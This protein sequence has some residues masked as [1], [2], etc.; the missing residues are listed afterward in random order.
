MKNYI[1]LD[2]ITERKLIGEIDKWHYKISE[3]D[4]I[5]VR[6][7]IFSCVKNHIISIPQIY[8]I[9]CL[10]SEN[11]TRTIL[12]ARTLKG[13]Y[14]VKK[15]EK[16]QLF[17]RMISYN[18]KKLWLIEFDRKNEMCKLLFALL[19]LNFNQ[20]SKGKGLTRFNR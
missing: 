4:F 2:P 14:K 16:I 18:E 8:H 7:I 20:Q 6:N 9:I 10:L 5:N 1:R 12:K 3:E 17:Y 11:K 13:K 19:F 15:L